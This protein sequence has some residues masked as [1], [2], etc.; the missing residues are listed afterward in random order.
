MQRTLKKQVSKLIIETNPIET[1]NIAT[2]T[3]KVENLSDCTPITA[4]NLQKLVD[5]LQSV[6]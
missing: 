3:L 1:G 2:T 4:E 6:E 5:D